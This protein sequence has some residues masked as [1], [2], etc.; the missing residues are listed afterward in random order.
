MNALEKELNVKLF[1]K[2]HK[3]IELTQ[4][5]NYLYNC[6]LNITEIVESAVNETRRIDNDIEN[7]LNI[8]YI[9][10]LEQRIVPLCTSRFLELYPKIKIKIKEIHPA[11]EEIIKLYDSNTLIFSVEDYVHSFKDISFSPLLDAKICCVLNKNHP[12]ANKKLITANNLN[13]HT[14]VFYPDKVSPL[15]LINLR[16]ELE[17]NIPNITI[18]ESRDAESTIAM[19]FSHMAINMTLDIFASSRKNLISIPFESDLTVKYGIASSKSSTRAVN[20]FISI[21]EQLVR[22]I[23]SKKRSS[24]SVSNLSRSTIIS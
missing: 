22:S 3:Q 9:T 7:T 23:N 1:D 11:Y 13:G 17:K 2:C 10:C 14:F 8:H 18:L 5:G 16:L 21:S 24:A 12:L 15:Y 20:K 4:A 19:L 6:A